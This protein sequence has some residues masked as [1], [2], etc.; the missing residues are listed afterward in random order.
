M[1]LGTLNREITVEK[2]SVTQ[3]LIYGTEVVAW[4]PLSI[5]PGSPEV[6]ERFA[7]EVTDVSA[8]RSE[9]VLRGDLVLARNLLRVR[10]RWRDDLDSSMRVTVHGDSDRICQIVGG[11]VE[12]GGRRVGIE[13]LCEEISA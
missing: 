13:L 12:F 7:A 6:A 1:R 3:D 9:G 11:P 4:V 5:L 8:S 2:K 10:L